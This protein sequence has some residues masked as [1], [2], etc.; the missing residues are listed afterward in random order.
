MKLLKEKVTDL[1]VKVVYEDGLDE[2][3]QALKDQGLFDGSKDASYAILDEKGQGTIYYGIGKEAD[4]DPYKCTTY[5]HH[6]GK[7]LQKLKIHKIHL[8]V[9]ESFKDDKEFP[10][11]TF[12]GLYQAEYRFD[13]YKTKEDNCTRYLSSH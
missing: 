5:F 10:G 11:K 2:T 3:G 4:N 12:E 6:L 13:H 8:E 1:V 7:Y 9:P